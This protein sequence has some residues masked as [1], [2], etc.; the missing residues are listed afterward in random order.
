GGSDPPRSEDPHAA[1]GR[2]AAGCGGGPRR[3]RAAAEVVGA[4]VGPADERRAEHRGTVIGGEQLLT[5]DRG[6]ARPDT[7]NRR[8]LGR[9]IV[10]PPREPGRR[11]RA[12]L[13]EQPGGFG[14]GHA[15]QLPPT[16]FHAFPG[17]PVMFHK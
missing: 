8:R 6:P 11:L 16:P 7:W 5:P 4:P 9:E 15:T 10:A 1:Q 14:A 12:H 13:G 17:T 3:S 2:P